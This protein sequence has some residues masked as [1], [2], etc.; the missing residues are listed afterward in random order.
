MILIHIGSINGLSIKVP[1]SFAVWFVS[2]V[3]ANSWW[4]RLQYVMIY[5]LICV[6]LQHCNDVLCRYEAIPEIIMHN[7][8]TKSLFLDLNFK[9]VTI[10]ERIIMV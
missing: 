10:N 1:C 5:D 4:M 9:S 6:K 2:D 3:A 7:H 8:K